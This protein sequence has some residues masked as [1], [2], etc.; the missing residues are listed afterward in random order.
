M[1][2]INWSGLRSALFGAGRSSAAAPAAEPGPD[3]PVVIETEPVQADAQATEP[4]AAAPPE[5]MMATLR[6]QEPPTPVQIHEEETRASLERS[7]KWRA[8]VLLETPGIEDPKGDGRRLLEG[9]LAGPEVVIRQL[10]QA[11]QKAISVS[12]DPN[13]CTN[14]L[15]RL[16]ERDPTLTQTLLQRANSPW[17]RRGPESIVSITAAV[18]R[19]GAKGVENVFLESVVRGLLCR[20]GG[21][22]NRMV[23]AEWATMQNASMQARR[24]A[25][26]FRV[27]RDTAYSLG[28]LH[29]IGKLVCFD[30]ISVMRGDLRRP[31]EI[32]DGFLRRLLEHLHE[33]L[34]GQAVL[35]WG[36]GGDAAYA[37]AHHHRN[38]RP[39]GYDPL[40][41]LLYVAD[42]LEL[43]DPKPE[44]WEAVWTN[45]GISIPL[46]TAQA[47][48]RRAA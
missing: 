29:D 7:L 6:A 8:K 32:S 38:P 2:P 45:G 48:Y 12:R 26:L 22:Y 33:P 16:F 40:T 47:N 36:M 15:V 20:P 9:L 5:S 17:Y 46:D 28:L 10:P 23:S 21:I 31:V 4:L 27:D 30:R 44:D 25:P 1:T 34:G 19:I 35:Y 37:V 18:Q 11:A 43:S 41:E 42:H 39:E 13:S 24:V 14:D 3:G